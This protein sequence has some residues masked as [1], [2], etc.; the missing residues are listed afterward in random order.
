M[1]PEERK[2]RPLYSGLLVYFP[3][4]LMEVAYTSWLGNQQ[5]HPDKP[6][7]WDRNKSTDQLDACLRHLDNHAQGELK[8]TDGAYHIAKSIWRLCAELEL[9]LEK[10]TVDK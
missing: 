4:A 2:Q 10:E 1:T 5:H 7:H 3:K 8:D 6:L 9:I